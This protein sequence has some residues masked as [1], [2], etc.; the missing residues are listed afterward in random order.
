[1]FGIV[2]EYYSDRQISGAPARVLFLSPRQAELIANDRASIAK[3][4][5]DGFQA[6]SPGMFIQLLFSAGFDSP[7]PSDKDMSD[8]T[9]KLDRFMAEVV[10]PLAAE[11]HA[12]VFTSADKRCG[13][14]EAFN[15][16]TSL[17]R[18]KWGDTLPFTVLSVVP[19]LLPL[20]TNPNPSA[21]WRK[22]RDASAAWRVR[23]PHLR[24]LVNEQIQKAAAT[25]G[26][27][28]AL[29]AS[30][31]DLNALGSNFLLFDRSSE[32]E[33]LGHSSET[34]NALLHS[35]RTYLTSDAEGLGLPSLAFKAGNA[36][37]LG[38]KNWEASA[39][40]FATTLQ[41][42]L[43]VMQSGTPLMLIDG[44]AR[45]DLPPAVR[46]RIMADPKL[47]GEER[48]RLLFEWA[49]AEYVKSAAE[50]KA[51]GQS[52]HH[53]VGTLSYFLDVLKG[54]GEAASVETA[55]AKRK[56]TGN[57]RIS[58]G[59]AIYY[60]ETGKD[61]KGGAT[62][63]PAT[64]ELI[65]EAMEWLAATSLEEDFDTWRAQQLHALSN[66]DAEAAAQPDA[67]AHRARIDALGWDD[68]K[69]A[70]SYEK[71]AGAD[72]VR[73]RLSARVAQS[74]VLVNHPACHGINLQANHQMIYKLCQEMVQL[75]R[76]PTKNSYEALCLLR[77]AWDEHDI[78]QH[79][80]RRYKRL[81]KAMFYLQLLLA[82][83][84]IFL[85][86]ASSGFGS[87]ASQLSGGTEATGAL[88]SAAEASAWVETIFMMAMAT[89]FLIS[90]EGFLNAK[91]KWRQMRS[92]AG[93][94]QSWIWC[95]RARVTPFECSVGSRPEETLQS[96]LVSWRNGL[97]STADLNVSTLRKKYG[98]KV[99]QHHQRLPLKKG[100]ANEHGRTHGKPLTEYG[101]DHFS[102][103]R[104]VEYIEFRLRPQISWYQR[105][106]PR[107]NA[108]RVVLKLLAL[109]VTV[110]SS[111]LARYA[112][113]RI[114]VIATAFGS[115]LTSYGEYNDTA[116][117]VERYNRAIAGLE[118]LLTWWESLSRAE[119]ASEANIA[120]LVHSG[121][122]CIGDER[123]AWQSTSANGRDDDGVGHEA[124]E[125]DGGKA[126][127]GGGG[128][129]AR[130]RSS[131]YKVAPAT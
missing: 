51:G 81:A 21:H 4:I 16:V 108:Q 84:I 100:A 36:C 53:D 119:R 5:F 3:M 70:G 118:N 125:A 128:T 19:D 80:A 117:K 60:H 95:F 9:D 88:Q 26:G 22:V 124:I 7:C 64:P 62:L 54:D 25:P 31:A 66:L 35:M 48:R 105:R 57:K 87:L 114:V 46:A 106:I 63:P 65:L 27:G 59:Q 72:T 107:S 74:R 11:N 111:I 110:G 71:Y 34:A 120:R 68:V 28:E 112:Y 58:L 50:R 78:T 122:Q 73:Q 18:T 8:C 6:S 126:K 83:A 123:L 101:D 93:T 130:T 24:H 23:S 92:C 109:T 131:A 17:M 104:A 76:L 20:Y 99:Y 69:A 41:P 43:D 30:D 127:G 10:I 38:L 97:G 39:Q 67:I 33:F 12:V 90:F 56:A 49:K 86:Q 47:S 29:V 2:D 32:C 13:L 37:F 42:A 40:Q 52:Y 121:E 98:A 89:S 115:A 44:Y 129:P 85:A 82:F 103:I 75:D 15:R 55:A 1:M 91:P 79:L 61:P 102:P 116:K 77:Q 113:I 14:S 94:L 96:K 45:P